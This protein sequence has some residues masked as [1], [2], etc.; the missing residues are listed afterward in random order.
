MSHIYVYAPSSAV[1][2]K[3]AFKRGIK[4][5]QSLATRIKKEIERGTDD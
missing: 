1:V 5:L 4:R 3:T 2:D